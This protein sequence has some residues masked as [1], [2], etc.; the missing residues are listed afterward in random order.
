MGYALVECYRVAQDVAQPV[1]RLTKVAAGLLVPYDPAT[2]LSTKLC[3][4]NHL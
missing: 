2:K 3:D 1:C 4:S